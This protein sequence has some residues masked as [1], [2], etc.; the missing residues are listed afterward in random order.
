MI[1]ITSQSGSSDGVIF[2][3]SK[4]SSFKNFQPRVTK[5]Q[6]LD[7]AVVYDHRGMVEADREFSITALLTQNQADALQSIVENETYVNLATDEAFFQGV[8]QRAEIDNGFL[9]MIFWVY[10]PT[11]DDSTGTKRMYVN[12]EITITESIAAA[13]S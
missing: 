5:S 6:T 9:T 12:D 1:S 7:G 10:V 13:V 11:A 2:Q 4:K 8:I 3:E